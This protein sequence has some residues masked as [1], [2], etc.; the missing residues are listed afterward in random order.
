MQAINRKISSECLQQSPWDWWTGLKSVSLSHGLGLKYSSFKPSA[1]P[2][3]FYW[4]LLFST[5]YPDWHC[6]LPPFLN[7]YCWQKSLGHSLKNKLQKRKKKKEDTVSALKRTISFCTWD[8]QLY[9]TSQNSL[10]HY[11]SYIGSVCTNTFS[12]LAFACHYRL[13]LRPPTYK[14]TSG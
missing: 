3:M 12:F 11:M 13:T 7:A 1:K 5:M 2:D 4:K 8:S 14:V 10:G 6:Q 9:Y